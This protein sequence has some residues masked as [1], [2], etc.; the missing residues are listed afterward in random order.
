MVFRELYVRELLDKVVTL[1]FALIV[2]LALLVSFSAIIGFKD[3]Y[4]QGTNTS[5]AVRQKLEKELREASSTRLVDAIAVQNV[6]NLPPRLSELLV[7]DNRESFPNHFEFNC[8]VMKTP[9]VT[10]P[11]NPFYEK[12][13]VPDWYFIIAAL[14]SFLALTLAY[15]TVS[16]EKSGGTLALVMSCP[17]SLLLFS[18]KLSSSGLFP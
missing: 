13:V 6:Y 11:S 12:P 7:T 14:F 9:Q 2:F 4:F 3:Y 10:A 15:D 1:R 17:F 16:G 18:G 8:L 5:I